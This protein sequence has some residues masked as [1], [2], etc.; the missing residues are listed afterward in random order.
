MVASPSRE[1]PPADGDHGRLMPRGLTALIENLLAASKLQAEGM[2]LRYTE[3]SLPKLAAAEVARFQPQTDQHRLLLEFPAD[4]PLVPVDV[5]RLHQVFGN[6]ISN[7]IKY[8][9]DGGDI[10]IGG[11]YTDD[12]VRVTEGTIDTH[13]RFFSEEEDDALL[14]N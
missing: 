7:A 4:F 1:S 11:T 3:V 2:R 9:P 10:R 14:P 5:E 8:S 12:E 13:M 6:L